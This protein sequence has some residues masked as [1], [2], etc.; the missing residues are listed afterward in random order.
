MN[1]NKLPEIDSIDALEKFLDTND[2]MAFEDELEEVDEA[3]FERE[4]AVTIRLQPEEA[5]AVHE[6]AALKGIHDTE[7]I[8]EWVREKLQAV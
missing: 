7:L 5:Q 6:L 8:Y 3:V 2:I 1:G 4:T